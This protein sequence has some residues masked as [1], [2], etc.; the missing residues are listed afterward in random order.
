MNDVSTVSYRLCINGDH[1]NLMVAKRGIRQ[2]DPISPFL[3]VLVMEYM[4][5]LLHRMQL[6][7]NFNHHSR[8]EKLAITHLTFVDD[9]LLFTRGDKGFIDLMLQIMN[10]FYNSTGLFINPTKCN[11]YFGT[12]EEE[13]K[14][15]ILESTGF[16]EGQMP[17]R[18][19]GVPITCKK[20]YVNHYLPLIDK[21]LG[22]INHWSAKLLSIAG[23]I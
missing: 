18:Y 4:S 10:A 7:P 8:C 5:R 9:S 15:D 12:V 16:N 13:I 6:N 14:Q 1:S 17:F 23:R 2:G 3:F 20:L 22:R 11:V 19:L 21:I